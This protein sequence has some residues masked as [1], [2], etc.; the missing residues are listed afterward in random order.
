MEGIV[1][2]QEG[3]GFVRAGGLACLLPFL[4]KLV[5]NR[6]RG[7]LALKGEKT[8]ECF[9][10]RARAIDVKLM[11]RARHT[12]ATEPSDGAHVAALLRRC[13]REAA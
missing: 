11:S 8:D 10:K 7:G 12:V 1:V 6:V 4:A 13:A 2:A 3:V 9:A 5:V